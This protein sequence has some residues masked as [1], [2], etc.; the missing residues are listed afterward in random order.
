MVYIVLACSVALATFMPF[1]VRAFT[2]TERSLH[3][4][5]SSV[6]A[7]S[8]Y[9]VSFTAKQSAS[10]FVIDFC[11]NTPLIGQVCTTPMDFSAEAAAS[12]HP[13]FDDVTGATGRVVVAGEVGADD[14]IEVAITGI[15]NPSVDGVV[16][17]RI[18]TFDTKQN[19][20]DASPTSLVGNQDEG[21]VAVVI[22]PTIGVSGTVLETLTFCVSAEPIIDDCETVTPPALT[23][24][25]EVGGGGKV[26]QTGVLSQGSLYVQLTTNAYGGAIVR[27]KST[28]EGCGGLFL[29]GAPE[30]CYILPA[31][32]QGINPAA[33]QA[34]FGI[35]TTA[36]APTPSR[37]ATGVL[38]PA[39]GS[40]YNNDA[41]ALRFTEGDTPAT[42]VTSAFG[43]PFL[44]TD[45]ALASNQ[46]MQLIF[47]ATIANDTPAGMYSAGL[48]LITTG[49]F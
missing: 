35:K 23:L 11:S 40:Y 20:L 46:N 3:L 4:S 28:A 12:T 31:Q 15:L 13:V 8:T 42:G 26:L 32:N 19:A 34:R 7:T 45:G 17:A 36:A 1:V 9:T 5:S 29:A 44:D 2:L 33:D 43:D 10:A 24:G 39:E 48:N 37:T 41:F 30:G 27:L 14:E 38:Q 49:K 25:E 47:G 22:T 16:Y 21:S 18:V 6:G